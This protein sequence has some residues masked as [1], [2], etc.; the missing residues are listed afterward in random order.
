[1]EFTRPWDML[2]RKSAYFKWIYCADS[3][4]GS[5]SEIVG[6]RVLSV[7]KK[8]RIHQFQKRAQAVFDGLSS[9]EQKI[10]L[11]YTEGV[12]AAAQALAMKPIEIH[13]E[14]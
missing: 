2:M 4:R 6:A 5:L 3:P 12:S 1:M 13:I 14:R 9:Q 10:L 11:T 8:H 7:D